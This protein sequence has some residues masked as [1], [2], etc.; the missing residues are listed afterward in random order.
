MISATLL[1]DWH[2][3]FAPD[4]IVNLQRL[5]IPNN[6][7]CLCWQRP[8]LVWSGWVSLL[9]VWASD[10]S[11]PPLSSLLS[12]SHCY[13]P[14]GPAQVHP[15]ACNTDSSQPELASLNT[16]PGWEE[17]EEKSGQQWLKLGMWLM[18]N[19]KRHECLS[20]NSLF[21]LMNRV[22]SWNVYKCG[23][24]PLLS[25]VSSRDRLTLMMFKYEIISSFAS[26]NV[27]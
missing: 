24:F 26:W 23:T 22:R 3:T 27:C 1:Q 17:S 16:T 4:R 12:L 13:V 8:C 10:V 2:T 7:A 11:P 5:I 25:L 9:S 15:A 20:R 18:W 21:T 19:Q 14:V 6:C